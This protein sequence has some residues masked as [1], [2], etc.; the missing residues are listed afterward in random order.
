MTADYKKGVKTPTGIII[1]TS[2]ELASTEFAGNCEQVYVKDTGGI[3][4][5]IRLEFWEGY[6]V[7][8]HAV[9]TRQQAIE[10]AFIILAWAAAP[11]STLTRMLSE[12]EFHADEVLPVSGDAGEYQ[13]K[14]IQLMKETFK[15]WLREVGLPDYFSLDKE[16]NGLNTSNSIRQLLL[17]LV[18][19]PSEPTI[20]PD[21]KV[22]T[23]MGGGA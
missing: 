13:V 6:S 8:N 3:Q 9:L 4:R 22:S 10:L 20:I 1:G 12:T 15:K 11:P 21:S 2:H 19:E 17:N 23:T 14:Y 16:G 18:E 7:P 5:P